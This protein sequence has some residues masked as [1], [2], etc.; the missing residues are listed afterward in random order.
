MQR[1][2]EK[3]SKKMSRWKKQIMGKKEKLKDMGRRTDK[4]KKCQF[5]SINVLHCSYPSVSTFIIF[6]G[7]C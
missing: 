1:N 7:L 3:K 4:E 2:V 6:H 5:L